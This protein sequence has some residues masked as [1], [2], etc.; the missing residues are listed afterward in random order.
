M[1]APYY[2]ELG[3]EPAQIPVGPQ[4]A[5]FNAAF[6]EVLRPFRPAVIG[7]HFDLP[8]DELL[9]PLRAWGATIIASAITV[10][11][12]VW[13]EAR[14]VDAIIAQGLEAGGHRGMFLTDDLN[15]QVES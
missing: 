13:L 12:A 7:F 6:L 5:P 3:I 4:R 8:P 15:T 1:L 9:T 11:E 10:A 2:H 14:G